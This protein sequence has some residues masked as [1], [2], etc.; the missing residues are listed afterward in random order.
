M[1]RQL[2]IVA[3]GLVVLLWGVWLCA[4]DAGQIVKLDAALDAIVPANTRVEK[5]ADA[6]GFLEGPVWVHS[7]NPGYLLFSDIPANVIDKWSPSAK[8]SVFLAKSGF[9]GTNPVN[10]GYTINNGRTEVTLIGSNGI[11]FD[12]EGRI[13]FCQHG[14]RA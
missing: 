12:K 1:P 9:T 8:T 10:V 11:T 13:T 2:R 14:D 4:Q 5:V 7:T 6:F 3:A